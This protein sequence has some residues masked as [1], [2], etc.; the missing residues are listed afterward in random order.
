[1]KKQHKWSFFKSAKLVQVKIETGDDVANLPFL[2]QKF[3]TALAAPVTGLRFDARTLQLLDTDGDGRIRAPEVLGAVEWLRPRIKSFDVLFSKAG[4]DSISIGDIDESTPEGGKLAAEFKLI[5]EA[6]GAS[7]QG[8]VALAD[9]TAAENAFAATAFNGDGV[10]TAKSCAGDKKAEA[11][12]AAVAASEGTLADRSGEDGID[13]AKIDAFYADAEARIAWLD[14]K[15]AGGPSDAAAAAYGAAAAKIDDFFNRC[16]M[17][18]FDPRYAESLNGDAGGIASL[19]G[20]DLSSVPE[21]LAAFPLA[22]V[23][24]GAELPLAEGVNPW[25]AETMAA[26][27]RDCAAPALG[28]DAADSISAEQWAQIKAALAPKAAWR[29]SEAG[30][31]VAGIPEDALRAMLKDGSRS[32]L[33]ELVAKDAGFA[34][35]YDGIIDAERA[36]RYVSNFAEFL[37]NFVNQSSL[38]RPDRVAIYQT[39]TLYID[40]RACSLCFHVDNPAAHSAQA[41]KSGCHILYLKLTRPSGDVK[42]RTICAAVTAGFAATLWTGRNGVFYDRDGKDW[43]ATVIQIADAQVSLREAFWSPWRKIGEMVSG[44][45]NKILA[46][47][48]SEALAKADALAAETAQKASAGKKPAASDGGAG[49]AA[50]ASSVAAI[51]IGVGMLGAAFAG[52]AGFFAGMPWWKAAAAVACVVLA[53]SLPSVLIAWLK[54]RKR[55]IG[56]ILN[57]CGWAVNRPLRFPMRLSRVFTRELAVPPSAKCAVDP[58]APK[59]AK[60]AK[61]LVLLAAIAGALWYVWSTGAA[62]SILPCRLKRNCFVRETPGKPACPLRQVCNPEEES[63]GQE[64]A[65]PQT[66]PAQPAPAQPASAN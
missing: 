32:A 9:V 20:R 40:S 64:P 50:M 29:A 14:A 25:W 60:T 51:G 58:Y 38:Y 49:G 39:G 42:E 15:P 4:A 33:E 35:E 46:A 54:L 8:E 37:G 63:C 22:S 3:W 23:A 53:V 5:A 17:S 44:Q 16:R 31:A 66:P 10:I 2:D 7:A 24:P 41:A 36:V 11:A 21:E 62:D 45:V 1:M 27:A 56:A 34:A 47:R 61:I 52:I 30:G 59:Y 43:D 12:F 28:L 48:E 57:A 19:A 26:F 6:S 18:Q 65:Q 55:D 13:K